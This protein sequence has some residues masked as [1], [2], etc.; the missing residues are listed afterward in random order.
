MKMLYVGDEHIPLAV[1]SWTCRFA[2]IKWGLVI[3][4][5]LAILVALG[6]L[7]WLMGCTRHRA[8]RRYRTARP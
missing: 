7:T 5:F 8:R 6:Y 1:A 2:V 4:G 3:L